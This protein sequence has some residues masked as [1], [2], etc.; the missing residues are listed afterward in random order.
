[1]SM[2][3]RHLLGSASL[4]R[5]RR[6]RIDPT[7]AG[8]V[9]TADYPLVFSE[10][11]PALKS[12]ANGGLVVNPNHIRFAAE[13]AGTT[14]RKYEIVKYD[15]TT[16][17]IVAIT[18]VPNVSVSAFTDVY[19]AFDD[20]GITTFQGGALGSIFDSHYKTAINSGDGTTLDLT[21]RTSNGDDGTAHGTGDNPVAA[22]GPLG[23]GAI[24]FDASKSQ[25]VDG[26]STLSLPHVT[27]E[28]MI[29]LTAYPAA[30]SRIMGLV[31]ANTPATA[32][33]DILITPGGLPLWYI[34]TTTEQLMN[35]GSGVLSLNV[36]H[37]LMCTYDGTVMRMIQDGSDPGAHNP[38]AA[39]DSFAGYTGSNF[40]INGTQTNAPANA[41][42]PLTCLS[43]M[44][45]VS[46]IARTPSYATL[47]HNNMSPGSGLYT[48]S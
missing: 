16:G 14:I 44:H 3:F 25:Y 4:P 32:D 21:D 26:A 12:V 41:G 10:T 15:N 34:Y 27:M 46:D 19:L 1:M 5:F 35:G 36:W 28:V 20:N 30:Q 31:Q 11:I 37:H 24:S 40:R 22:A 8:S 2:A 43:S 9:D 18:R 47:R 29:Y 33:K 42:G 39:G 7:L 48:V 17:Q 13:A 23:M 45:W 6:I 38:S